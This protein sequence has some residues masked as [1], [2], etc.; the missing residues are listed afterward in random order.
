MPKIELFATERFFDGGWIEEI[1]M[2][3]EDNTSLLK[4]F[5]IGRWFTKVGRM[6]NSQNSWIFGRKKENIEVVIFLLRAPTH[7][8]FPFLKRVCL[9]LN[10]LNILKIT[11]LCHFNRMLQDP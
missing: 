4:L 3:V 8:Y 5:I 1:E 11:V 6:S 9:L 7:F 10:L 2:E